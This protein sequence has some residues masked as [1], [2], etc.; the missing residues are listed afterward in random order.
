MIYRVKDIE[1]NDHEIQDIKVFLRIFLS[2]IQVVFHYIQK[3]D[4][5]LRLM[6]SREIIKGL[7]EECFNKSSL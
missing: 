7:L 5:L 3:T 6:K 2:I 1:G 4:I